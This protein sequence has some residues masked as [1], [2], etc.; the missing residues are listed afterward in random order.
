MHVTGSFIFGFDS[1]TKQTFSEAFK[2]IQS[3]DIDNPYINILTPYFGTPPFTNLEKKE[4]FLI[5]T[6]LHYSI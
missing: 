1:D 3:I 5:N 6:S 4:R 2:Q